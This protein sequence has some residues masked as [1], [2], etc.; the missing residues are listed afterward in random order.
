VTN[1]M[2]HDARGRIRVP[3]GVAYG[4][5]TKKVQDIL[6]A[7][8]AEHPTIINDGSMTPPKVLFINFGDSSLNFEL[9]AFIR[10]I[11]ERL[12]VASDI[13]FK[14]DSAFREAGIEIPFPQRDVHLY[15]MPRKDQDTQD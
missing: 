6:L 1:W 4:S 10:N 12:Q 13:N 11:D 3:I 2:L 9:R 5:D 15:D 8:A 14:I 7:I